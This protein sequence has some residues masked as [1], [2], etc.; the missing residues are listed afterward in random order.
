MMRVIM[1]AAAIL[2]A[3]L[4]GRLTV[5]EPEPLR[6]DSRS[7]FIAPMPWPVWV[8]LE[9]GYHQVGPAPLRDWSETAAFLLSGFSNLMLNSKEEAVTTIR[10]RVA[11][12][13]EPPEYVGAFTRWRWKIEQRGCLQDWEKP[14][15][16]GLQPV[17]LKG[18]LAVGASA[19]SDSDK[20][21]WVP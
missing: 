5:P 9:M 14:D 19:E 18:G 10:L 3:F 4:A 8:D 21:G 17:R 1:V 12:Q 7:I 16:V 2:L 6:I 20:K 13:A 15:C 11:R